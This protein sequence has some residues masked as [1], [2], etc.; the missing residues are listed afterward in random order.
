[1]SMLA[2]DAATVAAFEE[3]PEANLV[4]RA[5][6]RWPS[7]WAEIYDAYY[8]K[9][10]RYCYARCGS[11]AT[12]AD[13]AS[14]VYL[15]ALEGIDKYEYRGKP[16][17]AWFYRIAHNVVV[18]HL[19]TREREGRAFERVASFQSPHSADPAE[20]VDNKHDVR[21][22]MAGLTEEQ[23]Q[24]IELR[25]YGGLTTAEIAVAMEKTERAVYSLEVRALGGLRRAL[26]PE[27]RN[28]A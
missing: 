24:V 5:K 19:R 13:L 27:V 7:T 17:L 22:A 14:K 4:R 1:M 3:D 10:F 20:D 6:E 15:E 21:S 9:L 16:L 28:A 8:K 2:R 18:D 12:A 11:E 23:Q 26:Q 25:Y